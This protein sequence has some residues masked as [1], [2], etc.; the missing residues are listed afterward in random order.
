MTA[1][2]SH[3]PMNGLFRSEIYY[4]GRQYDTTWSVYTTAKSQGMYEVLIRDC[5][6]LQDPDVSTYPLRYD[7]QF[8][9]ALLK[10]TKQIRD[11]KQSQS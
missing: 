10:R 3:Q 7:H 2:N 4:D 8:K 6:D 5:I 11:A 1:T 9:Q